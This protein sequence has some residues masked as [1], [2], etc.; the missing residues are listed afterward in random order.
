MSSSTADAGEVIVDPR[1]RERR[2]EVRRSAA[3]RRLVRAGVA[4]G[5]AA[6]ALVGYGLSRTSL[7]DVDTVVVRGAVRTGAAVAEAQSGVLRGDQ[8]A[9]LDGARAAARV[10]ELPWVARVEVTRR[11]PGTVVIAVQERTAVAQI[12]AA[13]GGWLLADGDG[14]LL[15]RAPQPDPALVTVEGVV[16]GGEP[17]VG[18]DDRSAQALRLVAKIPPALRGRVATVRYEGD[19][20]LEL[21]LVPSG[22]IRLGDLQGVDEK[23]RASAAVLAQVDA[24]CVNTINAVSPGKPALERNA[25]CNA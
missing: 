12:A 3:R 20:G 1:F 6:A 10:A 8:L 21:T 11:W 22:V 16:V 18:L 15:D 19:K 24:Q 5:A 13:E 14:R 23:L 2:A 9:D 7:L 4:A 25:A 17:G